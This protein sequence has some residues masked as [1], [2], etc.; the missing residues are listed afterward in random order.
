MKKTVFDQPMKNN[1][2]T[3]ENIRK[4]ATGQGDIYTSFL[5]KQEKLY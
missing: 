2:V 3:Y 1:N 4:N 5:K